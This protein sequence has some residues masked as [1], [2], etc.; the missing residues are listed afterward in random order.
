M[1]RCTAASL[2]GT[3]MMNSQ[4][5]SVLEYKALLKEHLNQQGPNNGSG[6]FGKWAWRAIKE[7]EFRESLTR[8][9]I[10]WDDAPS[11]PSSRRA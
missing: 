10:V 3:T 8:Q 5:L 7:R 1:K 6:F 4:K 11:S 9:N 2:F